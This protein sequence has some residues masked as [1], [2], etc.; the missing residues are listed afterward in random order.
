VVLTR[1]SSLGR[2]LGTPPIDQLVEKLRV[3]LS[4]ETMARQNLE[5]KVQKLEERL[6]ILEAKLVAPSLTLEQRKT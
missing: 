2:K 1:N 3:K 6:A 4:E 5:A